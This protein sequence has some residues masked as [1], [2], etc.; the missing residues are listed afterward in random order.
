MR[1]KPL[2]QPCQG[3]IALEAEKRARDLRRCLL[4]F[5]V[6]LR[7]ERQE[8]HIFVEGRKVEEFDN[9]SIAAGAPPSRI[10]SRAA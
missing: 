10:L 9:R 4:G 2:P 8:Q 7:R 1:S 5:S 6:E 3:F